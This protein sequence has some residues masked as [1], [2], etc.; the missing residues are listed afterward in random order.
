MSI[1]FSGPVEEALVMG[2][3][4]GTNAKDKTKKEKE[5]KKANRKIEEDIQKDKKLF[6]S[7]HRLLLLGKNVICCVWQLQ[8]SW[9]VLWNPSLNDNCFIGCMKSL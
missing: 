2:C 4:G 1:V 9:A 8:T 5:A 7:T 6:K 3:F